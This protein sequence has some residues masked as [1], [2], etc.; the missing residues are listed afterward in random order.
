MSRAPTSLPLWR[1][2]MPL[3]LILAVMGLIVYGVSKMMGTSGGDARKQMVKI[4]V[5]PDTPPPPPPPPEKKPEPPK[6]E[7]KQAMQTEQLKVDTPPPPP[8]EPLKMEGAAGDGDSPFATGPVTRETN[9]ANLDGGGVAAQ[10]KAVDRAKFKYYGNSARQMLRAE[11]EK[12]LPPELLK[13]GARLSIWIDEGGAISHFEVLGL[14]D[15]SA[16]DQLREAME[17]AAR[18]YRLA[19][20]AGM[21]QPIE[22]RLSVNPVSG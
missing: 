19:P 9:G 8:G 10:P 13:L 18:H 1:K 15:K 16:Q 5:L 6:E 21:P 22:L 4:A 3:L 17:G 11:L 2:A 12:T 7:P 20:P 14:T